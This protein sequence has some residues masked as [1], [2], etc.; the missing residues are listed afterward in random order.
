MTIQQLVPGTGYYTKGNRFADVDAILALPSQ[1]FPAGV[2]VGD[3]FEMGHRSALRLTEEV[4]AKSGTSPTLDVT[5]ED[6]HDGVNG[7]RTVGTFAQKTDAGLAMSVPAS[8][9]TTPPVLTLTGTALVPVNLRVECT[10]LGARGT[11]VLR[12]SVDGGVTWAESGVT[13]AA[14]VPLKD[15]AGVATGLTLAIATGAAAVDN[16]WTSAP[17]GYERKTFYGLDRFVRFVAL[18]GG[19]DTPVVTASVNGEAI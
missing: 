6:S 5:V 3:V 12:Y 1:A 7:W 2:T 10:T 17:L 9:G 8:N 13:S 11:W 16:Y 4:S 14:T 18:V 19:S 15:N